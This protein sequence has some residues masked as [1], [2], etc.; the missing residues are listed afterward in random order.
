MSALN[1][2]DSGE[3]RAAAAYDDKDA[4]L[5]G[6]SRLSAPEYNVNPANSSAVS[7][8]IA[9]GELLCYATDLKRAVCEVSIVCAQMPLMTPNAAKLHRA[10][11]ISDS[12]V[13]PGPGSVP[14][15]H[16]PPETIGN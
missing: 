4:E 2:V 10:A 12:A 16:G 13:H 9:I 14:F 3:K 8:A 1:G 15:A 11:E 5:L 7:N 6:S